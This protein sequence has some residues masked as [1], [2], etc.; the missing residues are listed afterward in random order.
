MADSPR[1]RLADRVS[2]S[3]TFIG[4]GSRFTGD[5]ECTSDLVVGGTVVG[6]G[7]VH[8]ALTLS[9]GGRWEGE[10]RAGNAVI[11]G[12]VEGAVTIAE[13]L[14]LRATARIKGSLR[15]RTIAVAK[16]AIIQGDMAVT[17]GSPVVHF[18]EKRGN[19]PKV[20]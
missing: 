10:I 18:E 13:K 6:D 14:E 7:D 15:A 11:A 17:S 9:E 3:P 8:G 12:E 20:N 16:G 1:R 19:E 2:S 4:S 5:L